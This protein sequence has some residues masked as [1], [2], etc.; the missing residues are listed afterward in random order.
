M[1]SIKDSLK[2]K[3]RWWSFFQEAEVD[4]VNTESYRVVCTRGPIIVPNQMET[5]LLILTPE[6]FEIWE[7]VKPWEPSKTVESDT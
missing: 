5:P 4:I 1:T 3:D 7:Q 2:S 6:Q